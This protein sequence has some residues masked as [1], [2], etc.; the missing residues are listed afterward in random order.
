MNVTINP[1]PNPI[2]DAKTPAEKLRAAMAAEREL[3][4]LESVRG[5]R[6]FI[7]TGKK[8]APMVSLIQQRRLELI[9]SKSLNGPYY[10]G[11]FDAQENLRILVCRAKSIPNAPC[12]YRLLIGEKIVVSE[13]IEKA[14]QVYGTAGV[15]CVCKTNW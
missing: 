4:I 13:E 10:L 15:V 7:Q 3:V 9:R 11:L 14:Q 6:D 2:L 12:P 1:G 5:G 8:A